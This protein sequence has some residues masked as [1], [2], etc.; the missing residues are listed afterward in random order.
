MRCAA[1]VVVACAL[2]TLVLAVPAVAQSD[3]DPQV[4][5]E[6]TFRSRVTRSN[7]VGNRVGESNRVIYEFPESCEGTCTVTTRSPQGGEPGELEL[8][9][10]GGGF[11][12]S[13]SNPVDCIDTVS[14]EVTSPGGADITSRITYT[15][16]RSVERNGTSY[17]ASIVGRGTD[18]LRVNA[19]GQ[20]TGC[21]VNGQPGGPLQASWS[22]TL[23]GQQSPLPEEVVADA[24]PQAL[25]VAGPDLDEPATVTTE[26]FGPQLS[27]TQEA[28]LEAVGRGD[29]SIIPASL[30]GPADA[31]SNRNNRLLENSLLAL[32]LVILI[33]FPAELFN[34]TYE[35]NQDRVNAG[36]RRLRLRRAAAAREAAGGTATSGRGR[37]M[38][39]FTIVAL[40]A[41]VLAGFLDPRFGL[42]PPSYALLIGV[43]ISIVVGAALAGLVGLSYRRVRRASLERLLRAA[44][45]GL[46]VAALGVALSRLLQFEPGYLYGIVG[47][48]AFTAAMDRK[49][50]GRAEWLIQLATLVVALAAWFAFVSV[51]ARANEPSPGLGVLIAD[52]L[53]AAVVIGG[54][55][56]LL[57]SLVPLR[58][59]PGHRVARWSWFAWIPLAAVVCFA[60]V[61]ILLRPA[62]GYLGRP[63]ETPTIVTYGLFAGFAVASVLFWVYFKIRRTPQPA[64]APYVAGTPGVPTEADATGDA[65]GTTGVPMEAAT[66]G[67]TDQPV[68]EVPLGTEGDAPPEVRPGSVDDLDRPV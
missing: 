26:A 17:A 58:F 43:F 55:E 8:S 13:S 15:I 7:F 27:A 39:G 52:S 5:G 36:L 59:L 62:A 29:R 4:A 54:I 11:T 14:G 57:F 40:I 48:V 53:L 31:L 66:P 45:F 65:D 60:F 50:E 37:R 16:Q 63:S 25:A 24:E 35:E 51:S 19:A 9:F 46:L 44:P 42:N 38:I 33:V 22:Y 28:S 20:A 61:T 34:S 49:E 3:E 12:Y 2:L 41:A 23:R 32:L 1:G 64:V 6:W 68:P 18:V 56:G 10:A 21:T 47:G 67:D 30:N